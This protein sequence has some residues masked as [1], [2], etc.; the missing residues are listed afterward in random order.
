[1][2]EKMRHTVLALVVALSHFTAAQVQCNT[3]PE[4]CD[5]RDAGEESLRGAIAKFQR[6]FLYGGSEDIVFSSSN[7][8]GILAQVAYTCN[9]GSLPEPIDGGLIREL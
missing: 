3:L 2:F 5:M 7:L 1:M 8:N 4:G 9:D 6:G